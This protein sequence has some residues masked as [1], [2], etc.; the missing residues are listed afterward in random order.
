LAPNICGS[1]IVAACDLTA[2]DEVKWVPFRHAFVQNSDHRGLTYSRFS[3]RIRTALAAAKAAQ[4]KKKPRPK[5]WGALTAEASVPGT[6]TQW[7]RTRCSGRIKHVFALLPFVSGY[8]INVFARFGAVLP[9]QAG[10]SASANLGLPSLWRE[11]AHHRTAN[12]GTIVDDMRSQGITSVRTIA[13]EL[14]PRGILTPRGRSWHP[15]SAARLLARL[16]A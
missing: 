7:I 3:E 16:A 11:D 8:H 13:A 15:T 10:S 1:V 6:A 2:G 5:G 9:L 12:L 4:V 14:N